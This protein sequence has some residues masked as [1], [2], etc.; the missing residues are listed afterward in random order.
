MTSA[1]KATRQACADVLVVGAG[2]AGLYAIYKLRQLGFSVQVVEAGSGVGGTWYWNRYPGCR[3]DVESLE[4]SYSFS[5]ALQQE[6]HWSERY[7]TQTQILEYLNHVADRFELR[8]HIM[9]NTRVLAAHYDAKASHWSL[10]TADGQTLIAPYCMMAVGNLSTPRTPD[11]AGLETFRGDWYHTGT[12]PHDGVN[13]SGKRVAVI[14]TGSSGVQSIPHIAE[15][16]SHL[17]VFQRTANFIL[18][19]RNGPVPQ[20]KEQAH[21]ASYAERRRAAYQTPFGISGYPPPAHKALDVSPEQREA[22]YEFKWSNG[23]QISFL[24]AYQDLLVNP[25]ANE[26]AAEF[27]RN[28]IRALVNDPKVADLLCPDDH[29]IGSKRLILDSGY[30]E[31]FNRDNVT[32]VDVRSAPIESFTPEGLATST[33][34]Y[35]FDAVVFATGFDAMTGALREIDITTSDGMELRQKWQDGPRTYLGLMA[36]G[37]PNLFLVTGPQSPGVKSNMMLSI[38]H[39]VNFI[40]QALAHMRDKGLRQMSASQQAEDNWVTHNNE[41]ANMT[42]YPKANSWYMGANIPRKPR[43][44]MPYVGGVQNYTEKVASLVANDYE[45]FDL[46]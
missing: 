13:F 2:V 8:E 1:D 28:K 37:L 18:P 15:Q 36:A 39:H 43:I 24:Y 10:T 42:L 27:V 22:D 31:T 14:G 23:G 29:P 33:A 9:F 25:Q 34:E 4:Y 41:V 32:L 7:G 20:E 38:E 45:G 19:A 46:N 16:A 12:W 11:F 5:E 3:C 6:W 35:E 40:A 30:F 44:F 26:T 17:T 21:K